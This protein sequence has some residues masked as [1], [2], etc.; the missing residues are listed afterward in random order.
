MPRKV[1][2]DKPDCTGCNLCVEELPQYFRLDKKGIAESHNNG[3]NV[4]DAIVADEDIDAMQEIID[5]SPGECIHW[6]D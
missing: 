3:E 4:Q 6:K 5:S 2:V 1:Y